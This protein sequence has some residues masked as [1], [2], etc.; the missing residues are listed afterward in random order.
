MASVGCCAV[1]WIEPVASEMR[2]R[3]PLA[4]RPRLTRLL[5]RVRVW[6]HVSAQAAGQLSSAG[7]AR[8]T[9]A[10]F[11]RNAYTHEVWQVCAKKKT[12][13]PAESRTSSVSYDLPTHK[14]IF[15]SFEVALD[16]DAAW[17][18]HSKE[19][20]QWVEQ[21]VVTYCHLSEEEYWD[22]PTDCSPINLLPASVCVSVVPVVVCHS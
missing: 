16:C 7:M 9:R 8:Q 21:A 3:R 5:L 14:G 12:A 18:W 13:A 22:L 1:M 4:G 15:S 2:T 6:L 17:A 20:Q 11:R 10:L 19:C